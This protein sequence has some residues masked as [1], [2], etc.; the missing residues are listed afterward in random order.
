[1]CWNND[2]QGACRVATRHCAD[3]NGVAYTD[4]CN[5]D[6]TDTLLPT[7]TA[8]CDRYRAC[9]QTACGDVIGCV[10]GMFTQKSAITCTLPI[11][12]TSAPDQPIRP[13]MGGSWS[14]TLPTTATGGTT[15][16]AAMLDGVEQP[17]FHLGL[18]V[19]GK[20]G[21]Q[22]LASTCPNTLVIDKIDAPYPDAVL[23]K[24]FDLVTGEHLAHV[25]IKIVRQCTDQL[26]SLVCSAM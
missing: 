13:C 12:P 8:L 22:V 2:A 20:T 26:K 19:A 9:Q 21:A 17:P 3:Q 10:R 15:C 18:A 6:G 16:L 25:T 1:P 4:E 7:G 24:Q 11:D 23:D 14:A 5:V